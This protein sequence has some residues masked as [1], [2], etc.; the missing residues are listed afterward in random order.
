MEPLGPYLPTFF[1]ELRFCRFPDKR[2]TRFF[3][4]F[5]APA[6]S[7]YIFITQLEILGCPTGS[8]CFLGS[9]AIKNDFLVFGE[10]GKAGL[11]FL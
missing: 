11:K 10:L 9:G 1:K 7:G 6:E 5:D 8:R 4:G 2:I 3:P